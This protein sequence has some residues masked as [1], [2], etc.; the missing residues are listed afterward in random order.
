MQLGQGNVPSNK[1]RATANA[2]ENPQVPLGVCVVSG[3]HGVAPRARVNRNTAKMAIGLLPHMILSSLCLSTNILYHELLD[4]TLLR[5]PQKKDLGLH[6]SLSDVAPDL[7]P[8]AEQGLLALKEIQ[9]HLDMETN[10]WEIVSDED[11]IVVRDFYHPEYKK[12]IYLTEAKI[13][14]SPQRLMEEY[15]LNWQGVASWNPGVSVFERVKLVSN[16]THVVHQVAGE[17][18]SSFIS[19]R[20]FVSVYSWFLIKDTYYYVFTAADWPS[21]PPTAEHVRGRFY[22]SAFVFAPWK[23]STDATSFR[24]VANV[25]LKITSWLDPILR[26]LFPPSMVEYVQALRKHVE[27]FT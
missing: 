25:D 26:H 21:L 2:S 14:A 1:L 17:Q 23:G 20:D 15:F 8:Y 27:S 12:F 3:W 13:E 9:R 5:L 7:V 22:P 11:G 19:K 4:G 10:A 16:N 24:Y 6:Q 18:G